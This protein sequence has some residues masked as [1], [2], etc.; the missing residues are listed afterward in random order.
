MQ[1][2]YTDCEQSAVFITRMLRLIFYRSHFYQNNII[3]VQHRLYALVIIIMNR[4]YHSNL[5]MYKQ[6]IIR[7]HLSNI[8][9]KVET[10]NI[11]S[12][13][14]VEISVESFHF[15]NYNA[16]SL[17]CTAPGC[18]PSLCKKK[19]LVKTLIVSQIYLF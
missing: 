17:Q 4:G 15:R 6:K 5:I 7:P 13:C 2:L 8:K 12:I 1:P 9:D 3:S 11:C 19:E 16:G 10:E 18:Q 14:F